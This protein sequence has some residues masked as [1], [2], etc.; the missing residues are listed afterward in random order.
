MCEYEYYSQKVNGCLFDEQVTIND[1]GFYT[2]VTSREEDKPDNAT[3]ECGVS[4]IP[5][6]VNGDGFGIVEGRESNP[7]DAYMTIRNIL[8]AED[9]DQVIQNTSVSGDEEEVMGEYLPKGQYSQKRRLRALGVT[10]G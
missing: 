9:F 6:P 2:I 1:D 7:N 3:E 8:P 4:F 5:W 10:P